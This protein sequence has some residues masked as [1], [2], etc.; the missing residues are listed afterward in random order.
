MPDSTRAL[1]TEVI[2]T[3]IASATAGPAAAQVGGQ[4][5]AR[6]PR[7]SA[8][9]EPDLHPSIAIEIIRLRCRAV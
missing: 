8:K 3:L 6:M 4:P 2:V 9:L 7:I 5:S 1:M